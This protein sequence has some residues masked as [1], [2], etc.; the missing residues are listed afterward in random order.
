MSSQADNIEE[1]LVRVAFRPCATP[2]HRQKGYVSTLVE[3][4]KRQFP[5]PSVQIPP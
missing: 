1:Q 4:L 5:L 3:A 2:F